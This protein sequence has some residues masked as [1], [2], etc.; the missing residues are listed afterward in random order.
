MAGYASRAVLAL[1]LKV[2]FIRDDKDNN[3]I[4]ETRFDGHQ[5]QYRFDALGNLTEQIDNPHLPLN[6]QSRI[7]YERD[8]TGQLLAQTST[9]TA[10]SHLTQYRYDKAGQLVR[11]IN[12]HSRIDLAYDANGRLIKER[13]T[14]K[15][16]IA[17]LNHEYTLE[18]KHQY[19]ELGNRTA[20]TLPDGKVLNQLYYGSGHLYNQ[21]LFDPSTDQHIEIRHNERN[22]LH[23]EI[24]RQ[25]GVLDSV[26]THDPMG[27]L[28]NQNSSYNDHIVVGREYQYGQSI[29]KVVQD[30][31]AQVLQ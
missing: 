4:S 12:P 10:Q 13:Q 27:R 1:V 25:Q 7:R 9:S 28:I 6:Q 20:T 22:K 31:R 15:L 17:G 23:Q 11:A 29:L 26:Y 24:T 8:L 16:N 30:R 3:L 2:K 18:L 21:S 19:D 14:S 5:S